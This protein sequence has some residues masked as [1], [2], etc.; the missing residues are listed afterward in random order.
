MSSNSG[1][2][3]VRAAKARYCRY[4]DTKRWDDFAA[5]IMPV[6]DVR[7]YDVDGT[8]IGFF[9][10]REAFVAVAQDYLV[11][12]QSIHQIHNEELTQ[13][14][15]SEIRA[16]WSMEDYII[17]PKG[18]PS[19]HHGFGH[20]HE[21]WVRTPDGWRLASLELRRTILEITP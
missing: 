5:L 17:F 14:S 10:K 12:A 3:D 1:F 4:I 9:D 7:F 18:S 21:T 16:T 19:R 20:Y 6:P 15:E 2:D 8:L 13:V 11:G